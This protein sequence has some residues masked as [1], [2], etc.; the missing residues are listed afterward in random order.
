MEPLSADT[1]EI[2]ASTVLRSVREV[3]NEIPFT[4]VYPTPLKADTLLFCTADMRSCPNRYYS[5]G[6]HYGQHILHTLHKMSNGLSLYLVWAQVAHIHWLPRHCSS[7]WPANGWD[8]VR[9]RARALAQPYC[10]IMQLR[11]ARV[12]HINHNRDP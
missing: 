10:C 4:Y 5:V 11:N 8:R 2:R 6:L 12:P 1:P 3:P 9:G 7:S